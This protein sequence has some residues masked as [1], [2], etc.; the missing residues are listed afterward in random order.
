MAMNLQDRI[1][2]ELNQQM[3]SAVDFEIL[4]NVLVKMC[5]WH[6]IDLG[7]FKNNEHAVNITTW[8]QENIKGNWK[9]NG[10]HFIF[11]KSNDALM[12]TLKWL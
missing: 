1:L 10:C 7:R 4:T 2:E 3:C 9:R 8:C 6:R 12:F 5:D 11:E